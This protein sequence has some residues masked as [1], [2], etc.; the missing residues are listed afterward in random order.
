[1]V[2]SSGPASGLHLNGATIMTTPTDKH[3]RIAR[4]AGYAGVEVRAERL[5]TP[6]AVEELRAA[7]ELIREGEVWSLNGIQI[8]IDATSTAA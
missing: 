6:D 4:D 7:A 8:K 1:M 3:V 2:E 5:L